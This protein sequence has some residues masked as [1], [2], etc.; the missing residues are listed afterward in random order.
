MFGLSLS[1]TVIVVILIILL[2][3]VVGYMLGMINK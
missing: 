3:F 1:E 2:A